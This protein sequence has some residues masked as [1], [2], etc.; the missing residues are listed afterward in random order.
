[1]WCGPGFSF[2]YRREGNIE[3]LADHSIED[4]FGLYV[5]PPLADMHGPISSS[6]IRASLAQGDVAT[7]SALLGRRYSLTGK[8]VH[9]AGRGRRMCVP[10]ANLD[11][12]PELVVPANG[13]YAAWAVR[14]EKRYLSAV[15]V[16][17]RP[18]FADGRTA[19]VAVEAHLLDFEGDLYD[20]DAQRGVCPPAAR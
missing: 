5:V 7:A 16:G 18:T 15:S 12:W 14:G 1:M 4:G 13:V 6:R 11:F 2:G 19:A 3:Y 9:G 17:I 10:T 20:A 8:V